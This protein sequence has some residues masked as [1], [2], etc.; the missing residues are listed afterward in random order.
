MRNR[1]PPT[2]RRGCPLAY[3]FALRSFKKRRANGFPFAS[4]AIGQRPCLE[5][6]DHAVHP[7]QDDMRCHG[8]NDVGLVVEPRNGRTG[9]PAITAYRGTGTRGISRPG[10]CPKHRPRRDMG[11]LGRSS[12]SLRIRRIVAHTAPPRQH[13]KRGAFYTTASP[14]EHFHRPRARAGPAAGCGAPAARPGTRGRRRL[15][16]GAGAGLGP[17]R[18]RLRTRPLPLGRDLRLGK[19]PD[20]RR[21]LRR[22]AGGGSGRTP[23]ARARGGAA[24]GRRAQAPNQE[25]VRSTTQRRG[26]TTKPVMSAVRLTISTLRVGILATACSTWRA[27]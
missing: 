27:L 16:R 1:S 20:R 10:H 24:P 11:Q 21:R 25:N 7:R 13:L 23:P 22:G 15:D 18:A 6:R 9:A 19:R 4:G 3:I 14:V 12:R 8:A 2:R 5:V 17:V 26:N